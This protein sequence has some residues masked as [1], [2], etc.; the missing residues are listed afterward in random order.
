MS[1][2]DRHCR[3]EGATEPKNQRCLVGILY[4]SSSEPKPTN[5]AAVP[6]GAVWVG[7]L[8]KAN[9]SKLLRGCVAGDTGLVGMTDF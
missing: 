4:V 5:T 6:T 7:S 8:P 1:S 9:C 2:V 3:E